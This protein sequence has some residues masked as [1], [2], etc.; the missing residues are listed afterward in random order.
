MKA[1]WEDIKFFWSNK[2]Y[3]A[4]ISLAAVCGYGFKIAHETIG[5]DDTCIPLYFEEGLTP[6][7]GRWTLYLINKLFHISDFAPWITE[8]A[9]VL[10]MLLA[11]T[12]W[13]V[14]FSRITGRD[15]YMAGYTFFSALFISCPLISEIYVYYLHNGVSLSY[16]LTAIALLLLLKT[17]EAERY[18]SR[19]FIES[20]AIV[21]YINILSP[22]SR[23]IYR[24]FNVQ[25]ILIIRS[26]IITAL[27][28]SYSW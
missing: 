11:A 17:L 7:V 4:V 5:I 15:R 6:A 10:L 23:I 24:R 3:A 1:L 2:V 8:V 12:V 22:T 18:I 14:A 9:G 25:T 20:G 21:I 16:G 27:C 26:S 13:C 19:I 28:F